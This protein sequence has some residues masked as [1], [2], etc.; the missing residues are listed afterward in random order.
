MTRNKRKKPKTQRRPV[1][2]HKPKKQRKYVYD[3][4]GN[5]LYEPVPWEYSP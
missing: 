2:K 4:E 5:I 3:L 1:I